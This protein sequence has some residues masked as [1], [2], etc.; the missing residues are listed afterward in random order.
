MLQSGATDVIELADG[1]VITIDDEWLV[2]FNS[3]ADLR[4]N[5]EDL[6]SR[7]FLRLKSAKLPWCLRSCAPDS[8]ARS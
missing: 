7:P 1:R 5:I 4:R 3:M 6:G 2:V 8:N